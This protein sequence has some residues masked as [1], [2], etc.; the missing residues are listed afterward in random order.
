MPGNKL[1]NLCLLCSDLQWRTVL[2][3]FHFFSGYNLYN[4][5]NNLAQ[6]TGSFE[7]LSNGSN[8]FV[9]QMVQEWPIQWCGAESLDRAVSIIGEY[10]WWEKNTWHSVF[11][12]WHLTCMNINVV[13]SC[14]IYLKANEVEMIALSGVQKNTFHLIFSRPQVKS[15]FCSHDGYLNI[16][17]LICG[18]FKITNRKISLLHLVNI[19]TTHSDG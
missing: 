11:V 6:Q 15:L 8:K 19:L 4:E 13:I 10:T 16:Y 5:P 1:C 3:L 14:V 17:K 7:I 2:Y 18:P 9:R 12:K